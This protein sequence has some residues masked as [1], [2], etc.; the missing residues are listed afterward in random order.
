MFTLVVK[1]VNKKNESIIIKEPFILLDDSIHILKNKLFYHFSN[2]IPNIL[3]V[4][5]NNKI[6]KDSDSLIFEYFDTN[7]LLEDECVV[8]IT[9]LYDILQEYKIERLDI[10]NNNQEQ[11][12]NLFNELKFE[13]NDLTEDDL[14]FLILLILLNKNSHNVSRQEI[15]NHIQITQVQRNKLLINYSKQDSDL[16]LNKFYELSREMEFDFI[17]DINITFNFINFTI[18]GDNV[19]IGSKGLFIKLNEIYNIFEL[20]DNIPFIAL[21]RKNF[22]SDNLNRQ[23]QIKIYN[24]LINTTTDK[25]IKNWVLNE[26]KKSN[27]AKYKIIK[28]LLIKSRFGIHNFLSINILPNGIINV[29]LKT[30]EISVLDDII[31]LVKLNVNNIIKQLNTLNGVFL[32]SKRISWIENS[33]ITIDSIDTSIETNLFINRDKFSEIIRKYNISDNILELK[34]TES[35]DTLSAYYKKFHNKEFEDIKGITININDNK[36]K[37]KSSI[38][39]IFGANNYIQTLIILQTIFILNEM[40]EELNSN[41]LFENDSKRRILQKTNKKKLKEQGIDFDSRKC[42]GNRQPIL[43]EINQE[44]NDYNITFKNKN[45]RCSNPKHPYPGFTKQNIVCCFVN[46]QTGNE[47][48]IKNTNPKSLEILVEP[49][50]FTIKVKELS[51]KKKIETFVIKVVSDYQ[52]GLSSSNSMPIYYYLSTYTGENELVPIYNQEL[53]LQIE[54]EENIWL[55]RVS[56]SQI[57]Y[58]S[59]TNQCNTKPNLNNKSGLNSPCDEYSDKPY[60]GYTSKSIP[61]CFDKERDTYIT[62]KKKI[63]DVSKKYIIQ[64][65]YKILHYQKLGILPEDI[66]NLLNNILSEP[67]N[68]NFGLYYRMGIVQNNSSL[69]NALLLSINNKIRDITIN[70]STEF[71]SYITNFL[72]LDVFQ[73]LN[74]G[75]ISNKYSSIEEYKKYIMS[76]SIHNFNDIIDLLERVLQQNIIIFDVN[77]QESTKIICR[78]N[79]IN[80]N[81]PFII[82]IKRK[83]TFELVIKLIEKEKKNDIVKQFSYDDKII[84]FI[85]EYYGDTCKIESI[86][87]E[88]YPYISIYN[89]DDLLNILKGTELEIKYQIKNAFNKINFLI[90]KKAI[91]I[92]VLERG[93]IENKSIPIV[94]FD[95]LINLT[96]KLKTLEDY[97]KSYKLLNEITNNKNINLLGITNTNINNIGGLLTNFGVIIPFKKINSEEIKLPLINFIYYL[98]LDT[99]INSENI[100]QPLNLYSNEIDKLNNSIFDTKKILGKVIS[101]D[102]EIQNEIIDFIKSPSINKSNKIKNILKI[103]YQITNII[104]T[105]DN[106]FIFKVIANE[107]LN[108]NKEN[109]ILNNIITSDSFNKSDIIIRDSESILLNIDDIRKWI[110]KY[111]QE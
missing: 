66:S 47:D 12:N 2:F 71:K 24:E 32:Q 80:V 23:P 14:S 45:Y 76:S 28:G 16:T 33:T 15:D 21:G 59:A 52:A 9:N 84:Q 7:K 61:C 41:G 93:I 69:F 49:S 17:D 91:L 100:I 51:S 29:S 78:Q 63:A 108:D 67:D 81:N 60:F 64:F 13:Y 43:G 27:E 1:V 73:K 5:I 18:I 109:L 105:E 65:S 44:K 11:F 8:Y 53:I 26:K 37:E 22:E 6:V 70:N 42:Q 77:E 72:N 4:V 111:Q 48:Y 19:E 103:F 58:P 89:S 110:K 107:I 83:S 75:N 101:N 56:L 82:L 30:P 68:V 25:E 10:I 79:V 39:K 54:Q 102:E 55:E 31:H 97:I 99:K 57:I 98:D 94:N 88:N 46:K 62:R 95:I 50:N 3:K 96:D 36:Y 90:T 34:S 38:I 86:Y 20:N 106:D 104:P 74:G 87:P 40:A 92:P 35:L 85:I